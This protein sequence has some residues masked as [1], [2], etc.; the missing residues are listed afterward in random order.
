MAST[1]ASTPARKS[2]EVMQGTSWASTSGVSTRSTSDPLELSKIANSTTSDIGSFSKQLAQDEVTRIR[3]EMRKNLEARQ[4]AMKKMKTSFGDSASSQQYG[5]QGQ[6]DQRMDDS[7]REGGRDPRLSKANTIGRVA[8]FNRNTEKETRLSFSTKSF[9]RSL[10]GQ[11]SAPDSFKAQAQMQDLQEKADRSVRRRPMSKWEKRWIYT[12]RLNI[13]VDIVASAYFFYLGWMLNANDLEMDPIAW[14]MSFGAV[15][16]FTFMKDAQML[17][18]TVAWLQVW[19]LFVVPLTLGHLYGASRYFF[20]ILQDDWPC[21]TGQGN[22]SSGGSRDETE[23]GM[24]YMGRL[25]VSFTSGALFLTTSS[26]ILWRNNVFYCGLLKERGELEDDVDIDEL[27]RSVESRELGSDDD[28][29]E[30]PSLKEQAAKAAFAAKHG[31]IAGAPIRARKQKTGEPLN[32][33]RIQQLNSKSIKSMGTGP[34]VGQIEGG[35][36]LKNKTKS[37]GGLMPS[38]TSV[39]RTQTVNP[40]GSFQTSVTQVQ[41]RPTADHR[42]QS[43]DAQTLLHMPPNMAPSNAQLNSSSFR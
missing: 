42:D 16:I 18:K 22:Y 29:E 5:Q 17:L 43:R 32:L 14:Q 34:V 8:Q 23:F 25:L 10:R 31:R 26:F 35:P 36:T 7:V 27:L 2:I 38:F 21:F 24:C 3:Q 20:W 39:R 41:A 13:L 4:S 19:L 12:T 6:H 33:S 15:I 28:E 11:T 37:R 30:D 9:S 40:S 1:P